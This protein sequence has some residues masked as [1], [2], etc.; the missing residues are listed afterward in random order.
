LKVKINRELRDLIHGYVMS[1]GYI[2]KN[3]VLTIEQTQNQKC[4]VLWLYKK[5]EPIRTNVSVRLIKR[6]H[7]KTKKLSFSLRF[8]TRC[9]LKGFRNMWYK[10]IKEKTSCVKYRKSLPK[11]LHCFFTETFIAVWFAGDGTKTIGSQ[12]AKF[13]VTAF[14]SSERLRL[15]QLFLIKYG[16]ETKIIKSGVS[17]KNTS[18]WAL[19]IPSDQYQKFRKLLLQTDLI[20]N[21]FSYKLHKKRKT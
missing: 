17:K 16:L 12:G 19:T 7:P 4:F 14:S 15:K 13:E 18:Q 20:L 3:N 11:S 9:V 6:I 8:N 21:C 2:G 5:L 10:P 1:D